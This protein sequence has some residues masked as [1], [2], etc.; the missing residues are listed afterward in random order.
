M[1]ATSGKLALVVVV[2]VVVFVAACAAPPPRAHDVRRIAA[3]TQARV[4]DDLTIGA[5]NCWEEDGRPTC[6]LWIAGA[7]PRRVRAGQTLEAGARRIRVIEV[8]AD[9]V[10][11]EVTPSAVR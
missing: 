1:Q 5:G 9:S 2:V 11:V 3:S 7:E 10:L 4:A 6:G 8:D